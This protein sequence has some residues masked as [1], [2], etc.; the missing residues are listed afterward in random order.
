MNGEAKGRAAGGIGA[1]VG[2]AIRVLACAAA[3][4]AAVARPGAAQP[5]PASDGEPALGGRSQLDLQASV[6]FSGV[7]RLGRWTPVVVSVANRGRDLVGELDVVVTGGDELQGTVERTVHRR[8]LDLPRGSRKRFRF[9]V[10]IERFTRPLLVQVT[11]GERVVAEREV[12]LRRGF[13]DAELVLVLSRDADLDYLNEGDGDGVRVV[14]LH[15][16]LL[17]DDWHGYDGLSA[18]IVHGVSL[19]ALSE[20]QHSALERWLARGGRLAVSG[21]PDYATLGTPR[22]ARLLPG[23]PTGTMR[24]AGGD[25]LDAALGQAVHAPRPFDVNRIDAHRGETL[26][27]AR[28]VPL[29]LLRPLGEGSVVQLAFDVAR[30]PFDRWQGMGN[31][32]R[33]LLELGDPERAIHAGP[34]LDERSPIVDI[35]RADERYFPG[36]GPLLVFCALYLGVLASGYRAADARSVRWLLPWMTWAAPV[37]FAPAAY[38]VFGPGLFPMGASAVVISTVEPHRDGPYADLGVDVAVFS[39]RASALRLDYEGA[40]PAFR[41][42]TTGDGPAAGWVLGEGRRRYVAPLDAAGYRLRRIVGQDVVPYAIRGTLVESAAT[43]DVTVEN[44]SGHALRDAWLVYLGRVHR[45]GPIAADAT[46]ALALDVG[47][48]AFDLERDSWRHVLAGAGEPGPRELAAQRV[49]ERWIEGLDDA[50]SPYAA[51]LVALSRGPLR[52]AG[53]AVA[54]PREEVALALVRLSATPRPRPAS[55]P[56]GVGL[57]A[58]EEA[59]DEATDEA[60]EEAIDD[61]PH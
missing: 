53:E 49:V 34:Q 55:G 4:V 61:G 42:A 29:V 19:E 46:L 10:L 17:P 48:P 50:R 58:F 5:A 16:E 30:Y 20:A 28:G 41:P 33:D 23:V 39:N 24:L 52:L 40:T 32:W 51:Q 35:V 15:P 59:T 54:W 25:A 43:L 60:V 12:A 3:V 22:L 18:V 2:R 6:G 1:G 36:H 38:L 44:R 21:G 56:D 26:R 13:T 7:Y 47:A 8:T 11:S 57:D 31:L 45:L 27:S 37:A 9:T 14:Y